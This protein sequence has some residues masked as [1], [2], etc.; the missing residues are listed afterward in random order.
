MAAFLVLM[1]AV[2]YLAWSLQRFKR[3]KEMQ[4]T[5]YSNDGESFNMG[6]IN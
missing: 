2:V 1:V 3:S 4:Y 6:A 5:Q